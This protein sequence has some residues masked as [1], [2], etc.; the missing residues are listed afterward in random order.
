MFELVV[1]P[2]WVGI[3]IAVLGDLP[4]D[5]LEK[6]IARLTEFGYDVTISKAP[7]KTG[8]LKEGIVKAITLNTGTISLT[9]PHSSF[10]AYGT[11]SHEIRPINTRALIFQGIGG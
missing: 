11:M 2:S 1:T 10:V 4:R 3:E 7:V 5:V 8:R 6:F 9:A